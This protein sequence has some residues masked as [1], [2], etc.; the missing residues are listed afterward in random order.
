MNEKETGEIRRRIKLGKCAVN[1]IYGCFVNEKKEVVS[2]FRQSLGLMD[3]DDADN[4]LSIIRKT[5]SGTL[6]KNLIDLPYK[7]Q[8]VVDSDEHR[9]MSALRTQ[10]PESEEA[11]NI[12]FNATASTLAMGNNY[13][14][15]LIQDSYDVPQYGSDESRIEDSSSVYNYCLCA[16]CPVKQSKQALGFVAHENAF[17]TLAANQ[18]ISPPEIGFLFP[19]FDDRTANIYDILY[20]TKN[21]ADN[22]PEFIENILRTEVPMPA[23][24]QKEVFNSII[25]ETLSEDCNLEVAVNVRDVLCEKIEEHKQQKDEDPPVITKKSVSNILTNCGVNEERVKSFED[26]FDESF[27]ENAELSP[28]NFVNTKELSVST[29]DV[30]IKI[31]SDRSDLLETRVIDG[32]K[33]IMIRAESNVEVNGIT[34]II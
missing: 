32:K 14:I 5:L 34:V 16:V 31:N 2:S 17:K 29:P 7:N 13:L 28:Q 24:E 22:H 27:G 3:N 15:L 10:A 8:Q 11:I 21:T 30:S 19:T 12:F 6:G 1:Y 18:L 20:Y 4:L 23:E 26:K 9:L 33:Y 25:E